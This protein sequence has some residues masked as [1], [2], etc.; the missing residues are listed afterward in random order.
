MKYTTKRNVNTLTITFKMTQ[1]EWADFDKRAYEQ[2]KG[3]YNI[4]GFRK[5]H[6]P[7]NILE[8]RYGKGLFFED[9]LYIAAQEYYTA[10]CTLGHNSFVDNR[11]LFRLD[12]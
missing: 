2:N 8:N 12:C 11:K 7:K 5:G 9:A 4:P 1:E 3:K 10:F 6:V